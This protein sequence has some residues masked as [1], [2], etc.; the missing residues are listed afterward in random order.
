MSARSYTSVLK[1]AYSTRWNLKL[2][3][4]VCPNV[5]GFYKRSDFIEKRQVS[6][7][8]RPTR[9]LGRVKVQ[10]YSIFDLGTRR[11]WR[12]SITPRPH[13]TPGKDPVSIVQEAGWASGPVWIGAKN[14][15]PT[16]IWSPDRPNR[17][18]SLYRLS[19][20]THTETFYIS[21][22]IYIYIFQKLH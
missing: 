20:P 11:G 19:Y 10:L 4:I 17:R 9:P 15:A 1:R 18:Q 2:R 13:L 14:L 5:L 12:V 8:H 3:Y 7:F 21:S 6:P 16:G 22:Y